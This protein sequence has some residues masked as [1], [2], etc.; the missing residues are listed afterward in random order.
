MASCCRPPKSA[1]KFSRFLGRAASTDAA[2]AAAEL[3]DFATDCEENKTK[4]A[5]MLALCHRYC[6]TRPRQRQL[7]PRQRWRYQALGTPC[8]SARLRLR[9]QLLAAESSSRVLAFKQALPHSE[10]LAILLHSTRRRRKLRCLPV[11]TQKR[12]TQRP[13]RPW[14]RTLP[15]LWTRMRRIRGFDGHSPLMLGAQTRLLAMLWARVG[16]VGI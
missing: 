6:H 10:L 8:L 1:S 14:T 13:P 11:K 3:E 16:K 12:E 2:A 5:K 7:Q 4:Q 9:L 15:R